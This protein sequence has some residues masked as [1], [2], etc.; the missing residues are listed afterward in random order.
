MPVVGLGGFGL[1]R[2]SKTP[3]R[4]DTIQYQKQQERI[5]DR[6]AFALSVEIRFWQAI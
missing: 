6:C 1:S 4:I 2:K 3:T 5:K